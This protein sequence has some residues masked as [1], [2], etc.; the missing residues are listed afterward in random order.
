MLKVVYSVVLLTAAQTMQ[1]ANT[2]LKTTQ[3]P[4]FGPRKLKN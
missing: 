4:Q 3:V 1:A 2:R